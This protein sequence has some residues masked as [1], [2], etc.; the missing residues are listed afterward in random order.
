[1]AFEETGEEA[2]DWVLQKLSA[3]KKAPKG[4]SVPKIEL[5]K[6]EPVKPVTVPRADLSGKKKTELDL[7]HQWNNNG[8][9][10]EHLDPL[11]KSF[12]PLIQSRVNIYK[13]RVEIPVSAIEHEHK[14][15]FVKALETWDPNKGGG[16]STWVTTNLRKAGRYVDNNKNFARI[17]EN[18]Y[19]N[20]GAF[21]SLK[22]ELTEKLGHEPDAQTIHDHILVNGHPKL[23]MLSLKDVQRL[24]NEQRKSLI[25]KGHETAGQGSF[26]PMMD[27]RHEEVVHLIH[28][29]LTP[30]ERLVHEYT[31]GLNGKPKLKSGEI[32]KT[33][34]MDNS[35]V[36]KLR[37]SIWSK[38]KPYLEE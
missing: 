14:K 26:M 32:A 30:Q 18:V 9:K 23:G 24:S 25:E 16:L 22:S 19:K 2:L 38:M 3:P 10:P 17:T 36:S 12:Q 11:L 33:L 27:P 29:Q 21:N 1:M 7:Y 37:T 35:K 34:K 15:A 20:I 13:N 4:L 6:I 8:R 31:F 28:H 5:P